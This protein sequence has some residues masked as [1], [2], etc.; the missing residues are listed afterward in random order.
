MTSC[1]VKIEATLESRVPC[2]AYCSPGK[3]NANPRRS[4]R[5]FQL[6][7]SVNLIANYILDWHAMLRES[8]ICADFNFW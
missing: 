2:K 1:G 4:Y 8:L 5:S 3:G 7:L 6:K